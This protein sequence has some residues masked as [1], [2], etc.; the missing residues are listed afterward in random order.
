MLD[1][2]VLEVYEGE[3]SVATSESDA[4]YRTSFMMSILRIR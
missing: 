3:S 2:V 1:D 4:L